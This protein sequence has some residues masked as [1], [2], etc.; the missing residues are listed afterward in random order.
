MR[1]RR[2]DLSP[3]PGPFFRPSL[4]RGELVF[5]GGLSRSASGDENRQRNEQDAGPVRS[6]Q[7]GLPPRIGSSCL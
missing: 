1:R 4:N 7:T 6:A 5:I 2:P 3:G